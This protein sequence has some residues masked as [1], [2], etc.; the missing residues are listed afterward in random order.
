[1][2]LIVRA[3]SHQNSKLFFT[4]LI[5]HSF[6]IQEET[7]LEMWQS[8]VRWESK[9]IPKSF[10]DATGSKEF[11]RKGTTGG[12][13]NLF[14]DCLV[15]MSIN[16]VLSGF[17]NSWFSQNQAATRSR[18]C[19]RFAITVSTSDK[20]KDRKTLESS[21]YDSRLHTWGAQGRSFR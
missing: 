9:V 19:S 7:T 13:G 11:P 12:E 10:A 15:P 20:E 3:F 14:L 6:A 4:R 2:I 5:W 8:Y 1:M 18:S 21:T 17:I 16:L